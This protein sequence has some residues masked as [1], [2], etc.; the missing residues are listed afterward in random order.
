[1]GAGA[2]RGLRGG[3]STLPA[4]PAAPE[5]YKFDLQG[6][7]IAYLTDFMGILLTV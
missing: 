4:D 5:A 1:V 6:N 7:I 2:G 3:Y